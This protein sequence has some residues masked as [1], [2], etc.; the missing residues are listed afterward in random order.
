MEQA[1]YRLSCMVVHCC[2][3]TYIPSVCTGSFTQLWS[4]TAA[5]A[6]SIALLQATAARPLARNGTTLPERLSSTSAMCTD[7]REQ[8]C[9]LGGAYVTPMQHL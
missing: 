1:Q 7:Q 5:G 3:V 9:S 4:V 8:I 6:A 2:G